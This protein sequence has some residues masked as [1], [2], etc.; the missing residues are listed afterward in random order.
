MNTTC[1]QLSLVN[2]YIPRIGGISCNPYGA[3]VHLFMQIH[4]QESLSPDFASI[5]SF[6]LPPNLFLRFADV[7][8]TVTLSR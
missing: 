4:S 3:Y 1:S 7:A 6:L 2:F 8:R 5:L